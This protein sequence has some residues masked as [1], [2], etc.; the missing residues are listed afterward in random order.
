[1]TPL[2]RRLVLA[3]IVFLAFSWGSQ[4]ILATTPYELERVVTPEARAWA[5]IADLLWL[6]AMLTLMVR[7]PASRLWL[8]ILFWTAVSKAWTLGYVATDARLIVELPQVLL[9]E[10][11]AA[12]FIH[13]IVSYPSGRV[14][15]PRER[16][17]V[18]AGY[19]VALGYRTLSLLFLADDC[20]PMCR[21]PFR[22]DA[23]APAWDPVK[24]VALT[25]A[26]GLL[27]AALV[28]LVRHWRSA[29]PASRRVL[30]PMVVAAPVWCA[31]TLAGY[32]ADAFL[33]QA[34]RDATHALNP[35]TVLEA[36]ILPVAILV[37]ALQ[38]TLARG[39]VAN[40]AVELG[41]GVS[42]GGLRPILARTLR[43]P[44]LELAFPAPDGSG[45]V[46]DQGRPVATPD[47]GRR[48]VTRVEQDGELLAVL[49]D[50][51][52]AIADDPSLVEAVGSVARL[53][54]ANERLA[55]QVRAQL[56]EVQASRTRIVEAA[57]AE[58]RRVERDLHDG[59]QQRLT[60][61]AVRLDV[62]RETGQLS[63]ELLAEATSE[64][65]SAIGEVR[66]LSRGLHPTILTEAGLGPAVDALAERTSIPVRVT[67]PEVRFPAAVEAA[68][69]FVVA[70][71]L[72]NVTRYAAA[73]TAEVEVVVHAD[74]LVVTVRDDGRG[75][76]DP[77]RGSG[78]RGLADRVAALG[79]RVQVTSPA[80]GGTTVRA[81]LPLAGA[82]AAGSRESGA[83]AMTHEPAARP[84]DQ[85]LPA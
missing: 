4:L 80:G 23:L 57:D 11:W 77:A 64:L 67:A 25:L 42:L 69:Y 37:G 73:T 52:Q 36:A 50:D 2:R 79:G 43:D 45:L 71:S 12:A 60:A 70:E 21:N 35:F 27:V 28:V 65:R 81:E 41:R 40:L 74:T 58:R 72:T 61:L 31:T 83:T 15:S 59:A 19:A 24:D 39:N 56:A 75:G 16:A 6:A 84:G 66:D 85:P 8:I 76:A 38:A 3:T 9:G 18:V 32:V 13:I 82:G 5:A 54:L 7:Q 63:P 22:V 26:F 46:D 1:V 44:S 78:L 29:G 10:L 62:A 34:A 33:D 49:I 48:T 51:P 17:L 20:Q 47:P 68:A 55:A 14:T 30:L 53:A